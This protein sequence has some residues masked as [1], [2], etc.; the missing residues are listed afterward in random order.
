MHSVKIRRNELLGIVRENKEKHIKEFNEAVEDFK[1]AVVKI[2]EENLALANTGDLNEIAK[3]KTIPPKPV[4]YET[5]YTRAIRM[6]ELSV[7]TEIE[8]ELHDFDQL[9]Q[10]EWQWKQSF[11]HSNS[12]Y[13]SF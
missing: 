3:I 12:T 7:E 6:L 8:L 4:S 13:K 1:K 5:S 9:V 10:D 2:T 11:L